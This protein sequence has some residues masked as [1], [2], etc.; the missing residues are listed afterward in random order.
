MNLRNLRIGM[1]LG[2]GFGLILL[3]ATVTLLG[4]TRS[5]TAGRDALKQSLQRA[6]AQQQL[7]VDMRLALLSSAVAVRNMG[8][9]T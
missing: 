3:L 1:R 4:A 9:Q 8:L 6:A 5:Q 7:A 2:L